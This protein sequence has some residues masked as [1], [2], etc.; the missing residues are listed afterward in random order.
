MVKIVLDANRPMKIGLLLL[1]LAIGVYVI[2]AITG[3]RSLWLT[4]LGIA[5]LGLLVYAV[6]RVHMLWKRR[7]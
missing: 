7:Y 5:F 6:G 4:S 2:H 3:E 1:L